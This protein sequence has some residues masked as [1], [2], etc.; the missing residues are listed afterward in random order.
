[1]P[2]ICSFSTIRGMAAADSGLLTVSRT[3]SDPARHSSA[4]CL[5]L[6][7]MSAVSVLVIDCTTT[8]LPPPTT[9][10]PMR[11]AWV[12][13]RAHTVVS[14]GWVGWVTASCI[15]H[16]SAPSVFTRAGWLPTVGRHSFN[17][18]GRLS[19]AGQPPSA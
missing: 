6:A 16:F 2:I 19:Q 3:I 11:T 17:R 10:P 12:W 1:M 18:C 7:A 13:R 14:D 8:G 15:P 9:T 5:T 4:T